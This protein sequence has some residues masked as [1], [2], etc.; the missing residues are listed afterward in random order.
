MANK[1]RMQLSENDQARLFLTSRYRNRIFHSLREIRKLFEILKR[2]SEKEEYLAI[3]F[4]IDSAEQ[5]LEKYA[6]YLTYDFQKVCNVS[7]NLEIMKG[8]IFAEIKEVLNNFQ[9]KK[10]EKF[11]IIGNE[12]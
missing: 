10:E 7:C 3:K 11:I 2:D 12:E 8:S 9:D 5:D 4:I 6:D 1:K